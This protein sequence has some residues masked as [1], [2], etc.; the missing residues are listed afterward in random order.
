MVHNSREQGDVELTPEQLQNQFQTLAAEADLY[1]QKGG[2]E[3]AIERYTLA[4]NLKPNDKNC[5]V[6]RSRCHLLAG[7]AAAALSDADHVLNEDPNFFKAVFMKAEALYA[8]G[9]FEFALVHFHRGNRAR[10]EFSEFRVGVQKAREAIENAIGNPHEV[11]IKSLAKGN[12]ASIKVSNILSEDKAEVSGKGKQGSADWR[13][14]NLNGLS[15]SDTGSTGIGSTL[16]SESLACNPFFQTSAAVC[17]QPAMEK[18]LLGELFEDKLYLIE[19]LGD[20]KKSAT[21]NLNLFQAIRSGLTYLDSRLEFWRQQNPLYARPKQQVK[22]Y[23]LRKE[24]AQKP[25]SAA[26]GN[27]KPQNSPTKK[28]VTTSKSVPSA[29]LVNKKPAATVRAGSTS[30]SRTVQSSKL[31]GTR[32]ATGSPGNMNNSVTASVQP[33][34]QKSAVRTRQASKT[35]EA[36]KHS[37]LALKI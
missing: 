8:I 12:F 36:L 4:L 20:E 13:S 34:P 11:K 19:L 7:N 26:A 5:I 6:S 25:K 35:A 32:S 31:N 1:A 28:G 16:N 29:S 18:K 3:Q 2:Y 23:N 15:S 27:A 21:P 17:A 22:Y 24:V 10:P 33:T 30:A 14:N 9:D 37:P